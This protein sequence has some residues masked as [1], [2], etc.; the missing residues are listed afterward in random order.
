VYQNCNIFND[1]AYAH[2]TDKE[3][4][5][6]HVLLLEDGKP[7]IFG[8]NRDK[9]IKLDGDIPVVIDLNDGIHSINDVWV[10][11]EEDASPVRA[12]ILAEFIENPDLPVPIGCFRR[13]EK[14]TYEELVV[15]QINHVRE[16]KKITSFDQLIG[17]GNVWTVE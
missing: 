13:H 16:T 12:F 11:K 6:D 10:H 15:D 2:L 5:A 1:G 8:K 14:P 17:Q 3:T 7:M 4:K 9:G